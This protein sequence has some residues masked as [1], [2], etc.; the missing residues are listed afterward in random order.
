MSKKARI[1]MSVSDFYRTIQ[2]FFA[3]DVNQSLKNTVLE[4]ANGTTILRLNKE[5]DAWVMVVPTGRSWGCQDIPVSLP[6]WAP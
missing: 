2:A 4:S 3:S 6:G 1:A 5:F